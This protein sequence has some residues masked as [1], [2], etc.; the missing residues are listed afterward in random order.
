[1]NNLPT[2]YNN[3]LTEEIFTAAEMVGLTGPISSLSFFNTG[4]SSRTRSKIDIYMVHTQK[5]KF[6]SITDWIPVTASDTILFSGS[7]TF[8]AKNWVTI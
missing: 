5:T 3:A 8:P 7:V 4:T 1:M 2:D 6:D